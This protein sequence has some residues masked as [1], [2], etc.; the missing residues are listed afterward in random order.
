[1]RDMAIPVIV[2]RADTTIV[3]ADIVDR[4]AMADTAE[5]RGMDIAIQETDTDIDHITIR[6]AAPAIGI[7]TTDI[8][9]Q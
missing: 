7:T 1:M 9:H 3:M 6:I 2:V 5:D 4:F 8:K